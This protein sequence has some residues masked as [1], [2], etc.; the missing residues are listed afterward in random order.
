MPDSAPP[1]GQTFDDFIRV[2]RTSGL[3]ESDLLDTAVAPWKDATGPVPEDC[4]QTLLDQ[5]LLTAWQLE[6]LRKGR[7][8]GFIL[9]KYRLLR[10]L[11]AGGMSQVYLAEHMTLK[12]KVAIKVLPLKR[13]DTTSYLERFKREAKASAGLNHPNIARAFDLETSESINFFVM[14]YIDGTDL[15]Q[16][17]KQLGPL[18]VREAADFIRQAAEGLQFAHEEGFVH[19]DI[20]PANLMVDKRNHLKILDLGLALAKDDEDASLTRAYDETVL[21]TADY[22]APEQALDSHSADHRS[23]IYSLGCTLHYLLVGKAPFAKGSLAERLSAHLKSPAPNLL[24]TRTD[25][26]AAIVELYFRMM[27]KHPDA[28][29][30][31]AQEVA[32]SLKRWLATTS[33]TAGKTRLEPQQR[34]SLRR[35]TAAAQEPAE[36]RRSSS[37]AA[38]PPMITGSSPEPGSGAGSGSDIGRGK[39]SGINLHSQ[40]LTPLPPGLRSTGRQPTVSPKAAVPPAQPG[41]IYIDTSGSKGGAA[42][43]RQSPAVRHV[44]APT[45]AAAASRL[46]GLLK[47]YA[48]LPLLAWLTGGLLLTVAL[49]VALAVGGWL[50]LGRSTIPLDDESGEAALPIEDSPPA[51]DKQTPPKTVQQRRPE[52]PTRN[53]PKKPAKNEAA[54]PSAL[55][56]LDKIVPDPATPEPGKD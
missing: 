16:R 32:D 39:R 19:R 38:A 17:V 22:L 52:Q 56:D 23:D 43:P 8:K 26:P 5:K 7:H 12:N 49:A 40:S 18:A 1:T 29:Q 10:L 35:G 28:R 15:H 25:V 21:G 42:P 54:G 3:V 4:I 13:V 27:E 20:K 24:D 33:D 41:G 55:D 44:D 48:G 46:S 30:Q 11:G 2:V 47:R 31:S 14:E 51:A 53:R 36:P 9:G 45:T 34:P 37:A 50:F 6:Q